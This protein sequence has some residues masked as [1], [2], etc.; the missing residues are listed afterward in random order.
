[1][2]NTLDLLRLSWDGATKGPE[3]ASTL[4]QM[5]LKEYVLKD[6]KISLKLSYFYQTHLRPQPWWGNIKDPNIIILSSN[7]KYSPLVNEWEEL[8]KEGY[9]EMWSSTLEDPEN[10]V[11]N[12]LKYKDD[13]ILFNQKSSY[14]WWEET[15]G[16]LS[17][18]EEA[19]L[20]NVGVFNLLGY[21]NF[22]YAVSKKNLKTEEEIKDSKLSEF[23]SL[24]NKFAKENDLTEYSYNF[25]PT[26][27]AVRLHVEYLM[28][29]NKE[30]YIIVVWGYRFWKYAGINFEK[31]DK[32]RI[33][34]VNTFRGL[35]KDIFQSHVGNRDERSDV[36]D[37]YV[38]TDSKKERDEQ[39]VDFYNK[40]MEILHK[41]T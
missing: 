32:Q 17:Y 36:Y 20:K 34:V 14:K 7:P 6:V 16:F 8:T 21:F 31:H 1:M 2:K 35:N 25:F 11:A 9:Q 3:Y 41:E 15:L 29:K 30:M 12:I 23:I 18:N 19:F 4:D 27:N 37:F 5:A 26:Q 39:Y 33:M 40:I 10:N 13:D 24:F 22:S 38:K 28:K